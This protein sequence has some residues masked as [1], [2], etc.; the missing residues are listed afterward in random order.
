MAKHVIN[1]YIT[2]EPIKYGPNK[3]QLAVDFRTYKPNPEYEPERVV[4][5]E[6]TLEVEVPDGFDCRPGTIANLEAQRERIRKEAATKV[7]QI[8]DWIGRL[9][10]IENKAE[11]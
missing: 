3:G 4:V 6:H 1:G 10:A 9:L 7:R 11:A 2:A 8:D 5:R